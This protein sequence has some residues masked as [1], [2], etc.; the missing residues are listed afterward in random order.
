LTNEL[1]TTTTTTT[2]TTD[3]VNNNNKTIKPLLS[4]AQ[5]QNPAYSNF[6][7]ACKSPDTK[8]IYDSVIRYYMDYL[9]IDRSSYDKLL[10]K[11]PRTIQM[12]IRNYAIYLRDKKKASHATIATYLSAISK[13]YTKNF[14]V[15][16]RKDLKDYMG[17][18][19]KTVDDRPYTHSEINILLAN[20]D[21]RNKAIILTMCSSGA[22]VGAIS[23]L[24]FRD[25][26]PIDDYNIYKI[27][28]YAMSKK[29]NYHGFCIP[30]CR[31][32]IDDYLD[33][34][35]RWG[36]RIT[37]DSPLFRVDYNSLAVNRQ[38]QIQLGL[39]P[40]KPVSKHAIRNFMVRLL[41]HTGI[42]KISTEEQARRLNTMMTHGF[43]KFYE[44]NAYKAGMDHMYIRRLM[45]QKSG[46]EDSYL[47]LSD[48]EL[49][50]G[51]SK[52]VGFIGI[53]GQLT[54]NDS[55]RLRQENQILHMD[56]DR[57]EEKVNKLW[58]KI[59]DR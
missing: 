43:R 24:R 13:F 35:K 28:Y 11:D 57:L 6:I 19:E 48:E 31:I 55:Q 45:G 33:Y 7:E 27:H 34:R 40:I 50:E 53:I 32:A 59:F 42:R 25:L 38:R 20:T 23:E 18:N 17:E 5:T 21:K 3:D 51:D 46:L 58:A 29:H 15:I 16:N 30:E 8:S 47:K 14:I 2:T 54:I 41:L 22:R 9:R 36:E 52:H 26:T 37:E 44:T 10:A 49:L 4:Q 56:K 12:D 39:D 1:T